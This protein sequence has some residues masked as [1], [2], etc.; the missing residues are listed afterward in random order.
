MAWSYPMVGSNPCIVLLNQLARY[1]HRR[2]NTL[3]GIPARKGSLNAWLLHD[4]LSDH[5]RAR[6]SCPLRLH[7]DDLVELLPQQQRWIGK[8]VSAV[9][10]DHRQVLVVV[11]LTHLRLL[12]SYGLDHL[13]VRVQ[14]QK[15]EREREREQERTKRRRFTC[16]RVVRLTHPLQV[17]AISI[18]YAS[19][20][21]N[22]HAYA[23]RLLSG[24]WSKVSAGL[25][26][27]ILE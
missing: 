15:R 7:H 21:R 10:D 4:K 19:Q 8:L 26:E 13:L 5:H 6:S 9:L 3:L 25:L 24:T 14:G 1:H 20:R 27:A 12:T 18:R 16:L 22:E 17:P 11:E 23:T 2:T